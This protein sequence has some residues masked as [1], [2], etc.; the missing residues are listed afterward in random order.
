VDIRR[1]TTADVEA[2]AAAH[3]DSIV[4]LGPRCYPHDDIAHWQD[5]VT[6]ELYLN[7]MSGGEAFFVA[8][9]RAACA[10]IVI[11]FSSAYAIEGTTFGVSVY[12]RGTAARRGVGRALY[13]AAEADARSRGA[14][15]I[16][17]DASLAGVEFYRQMGFVELA[18][19]QTRLPSGHVL[20]TVE[21][22]KR[23]SSSAPL[24]PRA[25]A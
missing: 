24:P 18:R 16:D 5:G 9:A 13:D 19:G 12:V 17:I 1:A 20:A 6:P 4:S 14:T 3:R 21:M 8:Q 22:R 7:A 10:R 23:L 2:I 25:S 11:G 15:I